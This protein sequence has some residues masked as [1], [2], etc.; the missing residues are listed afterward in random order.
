MRHIT[1][2]SHKTGFAAIAVSVL[3]SACATDQTSRVNNT[4]GRPTIYEDVKTPSSAAQGIGIESQDIASMTD[5]MMRDILATPGLADRTPPPRI[6]VD[7]A[8]FTNESS[9]RL[10]KNLITDRMR[11]ELTRA[12]RGRLIFVG[13]H[14]ANMVEAER[15]LKRD[16]VTDAGTIGK[17]KGTAGVD[18][19]LGGRIASLDAAGKSGVVSRYQQ[20]TFELLDMENGT[21][22]WSGIYEFKKSAQDDI[23]YR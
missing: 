21:I 3:L 6:I 13:R 19:R 8:F 15:Q 14:L 18:Y 1:I 11:V 10:N 4:A 23:I 2:S 20:I 12:S 16:G 5:Q 9:S 7:S 17:T 22:V